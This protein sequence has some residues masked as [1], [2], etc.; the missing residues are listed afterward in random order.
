M[1]AKKQKTNRSLTSLYIPK[2]TKKWKSSIAEG[3][4]QI[5]YPNFYMCFVFIFSSVRLMLHSHI[6]K[7]MNIEYSQYTLDTLD[8]SVCVSG[9]KINFIKTKAVWIGS[10][11]FLNKTFHRRK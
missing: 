4:R 11:T 6:F 5:K 3:E 9:L 2:G 10:K 8:Y 7:Q 1:I